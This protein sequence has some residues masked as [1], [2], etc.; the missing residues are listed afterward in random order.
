[1]YEDWSVSC[2][3]IVRVKLLDG[4]V[5]HCGFAAQRRGRNEPGVLPRWGVEVMP[6]LE[7][8]SLH[9]GPCRVIPEWVVGRGVK[10]GAVAVLVTDLQVNEVVV[11]MDEPGSH[12][13]CSCVLPGFRV[14]G[15]HMVAWLDLRNGF[16]VAILHEDSG[17]GPEAAHRTDGSEYLRTRRALFLSHREEAGAGRSFPQ[18]PAGD[19]E[20][21]ADYCLGAVS[22]SGDAVNVGHD[23]ERVILV[24]AKEVSF[25]GDF[26]ESHPLSDSPGQG[27][28]GA[29]GGAGR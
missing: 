25:V 9:P 1:M 21:V 23:A 13:A 18:T 10:R 19:G 12:T 29:V 17:L 7:T 4:E 20:E 8:P 24:V 28:T 14:G 3:H 6:R 2:Q 5:V 11:L 22:V 27:F 15:F 16:C 26:A